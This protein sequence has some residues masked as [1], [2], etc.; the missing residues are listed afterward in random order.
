MTLRHIRIFLAVYET[1]NITRAA[2]ALHMSQPAVT[3]AIQEI[4]RYYGIRLFERI[5]RRLYLTENGKALYAYAVHIA[6]TYDDME[7]TLQ[8]WDSIGVLR[9]GANITLGNCELPSLVLRLK[10]EKPHVRVR[11]QIANS[12][13]LEEAL[14]DNQLDI[15]LIEGPADHEELRCQPFGKEKLALVFV[16]GHPLQTAERVRLEDLVSYDLLTREEGSAGRT[17]LQRAFAAR[18]LSLKPAWESASTQA[19]IRAVGMGLG[20]SVLPAQLVRRDIEEGVVATRPIEDMVLYQQTNVVWHKNKYLNAT[21]KR[22]IAL[23]A[24]RGRQ[25]EAQ[26]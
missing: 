9:V 15:A 24:E 10:E 8:D 3:R 20:I 5:N 7:K 21:A 25:R 18:D 13:R 19:L 2:E 17:F 12:N 1:L 6:D 22:F 11:V 14:L 26:E 16:P 4:E 23:C